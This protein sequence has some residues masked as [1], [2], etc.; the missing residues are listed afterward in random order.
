ML[1]RRIEELERENDRLRS[2][3][4]LYL[5]SELPQAII[6][7]LTTLPLTDDD[8]WTSEDLKEWTSM[9]ETVV[10]RAFRHRI[11]SPTL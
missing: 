10:K 2:N 7:V 9:F 8:Q 4:N 6:G 5:P 3:G 11:A 1:T